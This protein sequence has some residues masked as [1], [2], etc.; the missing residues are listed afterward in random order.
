MFDAADDVMSL[1]QFLERS[2]DFVALA[3]LTGTVLHINPAGLELIGV[4]D[5][6][7]ASTLPAWDFLTADG[8]ERA[9]EIGTALRFEGRWDGYCELR[10]HGTGAGIPVV[11]SAYVV[12]TPDGRPDVVASIIRHRHTVEQRS[13]RMAADAVT[14]SR[15]AQ[16]Q[17]A[18]AD[19]SRFAVVAELSELLTAAT[20]TAATL[21]GVGTPPSRTSRIPP[22]LT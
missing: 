2:P 21:M 20:D 6:A 13:A 19:L 12:H 5:W 10:H 7:E 4:S 11:V 1:R 16:E 9:E 22:I 3:D 18:L 17:K 8:R 15:H 14:A